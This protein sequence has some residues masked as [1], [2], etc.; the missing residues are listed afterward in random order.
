MY[1][2]EW[3]H[4]IIRA[5]FG[6]AGKIGRA[7][8]D[9]YRLYRLRDTVAY[10]SRMS[11][12][13][14]DLFH[15]YGIRPDDI[16]SFE[17]LTKIPLTAPED[18]AATPYRFL[19]VSQSE[20]ARPY[21]FVTTG[22]TGPQKKIFWSNGDLDRIVDF[23]A[24]GIGTVAEP[25]T[26][27]YILLADGRP[28]SQADLLSRG[29]S[30]IGAV[31]VVGQI[32]LDAEQHRRNILDSHASVVFGYTSR[33]FRMSREL[34]EKGG[35][36]DLGV[37]VLF[38]AGEYVSPSMR[39]ELQSLW[40]CSIRTHYGLT[41]MG[42]GVAVECE[43]GDGY[44]FNEADLLLEVV[45]PKTGKPVEPGAEGELVFTTLTR[46][47]MPLI[48]YRT[49]DISRIVTSPCPCGAATLLK[50]GHVRKRLETIVTL[51]SG[52]G[53]YPA[54]FDDVLFGVD[55]LVD[56]QL[57][58]TRHGGKERLEF[59]IEMSGTSPD[60]VSTIRTK[61]LAV[62]EIA[63]GVTGGKMAAPSVELVPSGSLSRV[64]R[65]K[66]LIIDRR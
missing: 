6:A 7:D 25:G 49:H 52:A 3:L 40:N 36:K 51:D 27:V 1:M 5:G 31:P 28:F 37:K 20:V 62:P 33:L 32:D 11:S 23:M 41:E 30:R 61:L 39:R 9:S 21:T 46:E 50:I 64:E 54:F 63:E 10:A 53:I 60:A 8:I 18:V 16:S 47:A 42:L 44:H 66:K 2:E 22:T 35:I 12:F 56:Y 57:L 15:A 34:Q 43:A 13:Y 14:R 65:A 58:V 55:G 4:R 17:D 45:D 38:L 48:R 19:C 29:V 59:R 24:A 26:A